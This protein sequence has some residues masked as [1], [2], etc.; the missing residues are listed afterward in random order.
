MSPIDEDLFLIQPDT[1]LERYLL[2]KLKRAEELNS[3]LREGLEWYADPKNT[4]YSGYG[5][6]AHEYLGT[7]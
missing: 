7:K 4:N 2:L 6:K 5:Y 1:S 3:K